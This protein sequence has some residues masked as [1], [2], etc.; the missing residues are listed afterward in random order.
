M[1]ETSATTE[2]LIIRHS[3]RIDEVNLPYWFKLVNQEDGIRRREKD[4]HSNDPILTD[5][6]HRIAEIAGA[7]LKRMLTSQPKPVVA[8]YCSRLRRC[9]ETAYHIALELQLPIIVSRGLTLTAKAVEERRGGSDQ[10]GFLDLEEIRSFCPAVDVFSA[11]AG[12]YS[13]QLCPLTVARETCSPSLELDII[14]AASWYE[15]LASI[16]RR[17]SFAIVVA[18]RESIRNIAGSMKAPYCC[19]AMFGFESNNFSFRYLLD[20]KGERIE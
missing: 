17:N 4:D 15:A 10:F 5:N 8:V 13:G 3:E 14:P 1:S 20:N 2:L 11:D 16:A 6:G 18:H 9:V 19:M 12:D 7:T